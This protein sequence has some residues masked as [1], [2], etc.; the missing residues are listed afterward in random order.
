MNIRRPI[1]WCTVVVVA[2]VALILWHGTTS[3]T[4]PS[5]KASVETNGEASSASGPGQTAGNAFTST[6]T[7]TVSASTANPAASVTPDKGAQIKE[8]LAKLNDIGIDFN[9]RLEDQHGNA[10]ANTTIDASVRIY[11]GSRS[12]VDHFSVVSDANGLFRVK[13]GNGE[14]LSLM[15]HKAG[16][17]FAMT[18][19][20]FNY[21]YMYPDHFTPDPN[22][23][24]VIKM[25]KLEGAEPLV[26]INKEYKIPHTDKPIYFDLMA[27]KIVPEGGDVKIIVNRPSGE[28]SEQHPQK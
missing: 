28:I 4:K 1:F 12:T 10:V 6:V 24:T 11:N 8:G 18:K 27:G 3:T 9:G 7:A 17:V 23:P 15:P 21:S 19:T 26:S 14:S 20:S 25:L 5:S 16:Y 22:N 13:H 2:L